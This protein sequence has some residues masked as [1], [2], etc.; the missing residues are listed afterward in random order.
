MTFGQIT[1]ILESIPS[2]VILLAAIYYIFVVSMQDLVSSILPANSN[3][4]YF[5]SV[6]TLCFYLLGFLPG[7][8]LAKASNMYT[9]S[10]IVLTISLIT[11]ILLIFASKNRNNLFKDKFFSIFKKKV[12]FLSLIAFFPI[13]LGFFSYFV[14]ITGVLYNILF[15]VLILIMLLLFIGKASVHNSLNDSLRTFY[16]SHDYTLFDKSELTAYLISENESFLF[17]VP[18][19]EK[20]CTCWKKCNE[21]KEKIG[22]KKEASI[23]ALNK[24]LITHYEI[25]TLKNSKGK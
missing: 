4:L 14:L 5:N 22:K 16:F 2:I 9:I 7:V 15:S 25:A 17:I 8:H 1:S 11:L 13:F 23:I 6:A 24:S 10:N 20:E 21:N 18:F 3:K 12:Y 19:I